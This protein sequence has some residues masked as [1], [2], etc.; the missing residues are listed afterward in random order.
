MSQSYLLGVGSELKGTRKI[1]CVWPPLLLRKNHLKCIYTYILKVCQ[2]FHK[3]IRKLFSCHILL[4]ICYALFFFNCFLHHTPHSFGYKTKSKFSRAVLLYNV[5]EN[6][7]GGC[8]YIVGGKPIWNLITMLF[9]CTHSLTVVD[10]IISNCTSYSSRRTA[11]GSYTGMLFY[12]P[13]LRTIYSA[14]MGVCLK[15]RIH[16]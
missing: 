3:K 2:F 15:I 9:V 7:A 8:V 10:Q 12:A 1:P 4:P 14:L 16:L 13:C 6:K 11:Q 5:A